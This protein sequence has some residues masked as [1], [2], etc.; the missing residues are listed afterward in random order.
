MQLKPNYAS[1]QMKARI[2]VKTNWW[3]LCSGG[4]IVHLLNSQAPE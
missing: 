2:A 4:F 1:I 3:F